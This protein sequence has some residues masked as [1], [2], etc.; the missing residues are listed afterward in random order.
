MNKK[1]DEI[2]LENC[3]N[4]LKAFTMEKPLISDEWK[5]FS[6]R[7]AKKK[8]S[9]FCLYIIF[10]CL[11]EFGHDDHVCFY[12]SSDKERT[13]FL[14]GMHYMQ[15]FCGC[16]YTREDYADLSF[17]FFKEEKDYKDFVQKNKLKGDYYEGEDGED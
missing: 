1:F 15:N 10:D 16:L 2:R 12:F 8:N 13:A 5:S 17:T 6:K 7:V 4:L 11:L 3:R 9:K 14:D